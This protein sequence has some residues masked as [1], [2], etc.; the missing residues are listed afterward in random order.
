MATNDSKNK[1]NALIPQQIVLNIPRGGNSDGSSGTG[2]VTQ[3]QLTNAISTHNFAP[4]SHIDIR[5]AVNAKQDKLI[6]GTTIKMIDGESIL[7]GGDINISENISASISAH[8]NAE[9]GIHQSIIDSIANKQDT[10]VSGNN[11]KTINGESLLGSGDIEITG[12]DSGGVSGI[13]YSSVQEVMTN[14]HWIDGKAIW[15]KVLQ[16]TFLSTANANSNLG[17]IGSFET[18][19]KVDAITRTS[20]SSTWFPVWFPYNAAAN[21]AGVTITTSGSVN[22]VWWGANF[23]SL[24]VAVT[25]YFTKL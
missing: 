9:T 14:D 6:S 2:D 20:N 8:N 25:I 4:S 10:L 7:S 1:K 22:A 15:V 3:S 19:V 11:I 23:A 12:G 16:G 21:Q 18:I 17:S 24:P 13:N 5:N